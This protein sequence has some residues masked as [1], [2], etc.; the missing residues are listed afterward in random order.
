MHLYTL[1]F[2]DVDNFWVSDNPHRYAK[3]L[4]QK[5]QKIIFICFLCKF[6]GKKAIILRKP[7]QKINKSL[8]MPFQNPPNVMDKYVD[9]VDNFFKITY[10]NAFSSG[11]SHFAK[12]KKVCSG[13][14]N[15][16]YIYSLFYKILHRILRLMYFNILLYYTFFIK[17]KRD[18]LP[19]FLYAADY[20]F[21]ILL[22]PI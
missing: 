20:F 2:T 6:C 8:F 21:S 3:A 5:L 10:F 17:V 12:W 9:K 15:I 18:V 11:I 13:L 16:L 19:R 4:L 22:V 14:H 7:I 1:L